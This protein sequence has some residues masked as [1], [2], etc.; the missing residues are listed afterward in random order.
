M[1]KIEK[2][3]EYYEKGKLTKSEKVE[4]LQAADEETVKEIIK[5]YQLNY[6]KNPR[7]LSMF[8]EIKSGPIKTETGLKFYYKKLN[9]ITCKEWGNF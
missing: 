7:G 9:Y 3:I 5:N 4:T 2:Y 6:V 8:E 1:L